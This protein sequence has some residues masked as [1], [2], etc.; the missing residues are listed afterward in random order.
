MTYFSVVH[1]SSC[2]S[3]VASPPNVAGCFARGK[4]ALRCKGSVARSPNLRTAKNC[5]NRT[6]SWDQNSK[7]ACCKKPKEASVESISTCPKSTLSCSSKISKM[8]SWI[9]TPPM[10][11]GPDS[12]PGHCACKHE[13]RDSRL[14]GGENWH[15]TIEH[16]K[17]NQQSAMRSTRKNVNVTGGSPSQVW[18]IWFATRKVPLQCL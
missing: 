2:Q 16:F 14:D 9:F 11:S 10:V 13:H 15:N 12:K 8:A 5:R 4:A 6:G 17:R 3:R 7:V 18:E 1:V